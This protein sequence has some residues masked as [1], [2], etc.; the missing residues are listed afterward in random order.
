[1][2]KMKKFF[3]K[4][5][6]IGLSVI[7]A[8]CI[9]FFGIDYLK[10]I[11]LFKP[12]NFYY[13]SYENVEGL[14]IAA[15]VT[16]DGYKVGQV[17][18]I[19]F[20]YD[21]PGKIRVLLALNRQL[22]LPV[23]SRAAII[24]SMLNGASIAITTGN[25]H[26]MIARG[27]EI[28]TKDAGDGL[29]GILE[30]DIVPQVTTILPRIDSLLY[31]LNVLAG[32]PALL[33][34]IRRLDLITQH[35]ASATIGLDKTVNSQLPPIMGNAR[36]VTAHIDS[37]ALNLIELSRTLKGLPI[38]TTMSNLEE[39]TANLD[40]FSNQLNSK[41]STLGLLMSD[42]ELYNKLNRVSAD[43]DSLIVDIKRNPKRY[44]SIKLL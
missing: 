30:R 32:D 31:S 14:A 34:S 26:E 1:M 38:A 20:N 36:N 29:M 4:E 18:D 27:G 28:P 19:E 25:S 13:A 7:V 22:N 44:I 5:F 24:Q 3:N 11:N 39:T 15:P 9:L 43:I 2:S 35:V 16:I 23:D 10:G 6:A 12:A 33:A 37:L 21:K 40:R 42:P 17:R 8:L 41:E